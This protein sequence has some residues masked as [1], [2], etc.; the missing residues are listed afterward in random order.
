G[1]PTAAGTSTFTITAH[2]GYGK[3]ATQT[4]SLIVQKAYATITVTPYNVTSD[5]NAHTATGTATG[6]GGVD[7]SSELSLSGTTHTNAGTY[8]DTWTF[9]DTTGNYNNTSGTVSDEINKADAPCAL[10][11]YH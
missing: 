7:L 11:D 1:T 10:T 8:T 5:G 2:N 3:D 4:F 6:V 9:T